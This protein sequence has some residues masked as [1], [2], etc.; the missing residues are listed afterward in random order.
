MPYCESALKTEQTY[1]TFECILDSYNFWSRNPEGGSR[2]E[3]FDKILTIKNI[4]ES[5][6]DLFRF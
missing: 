5:H 6:I 3:F 4:F 1:V 2:G